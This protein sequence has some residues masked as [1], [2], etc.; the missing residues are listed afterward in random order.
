MG[1]M[2]RVR[3]A[4]APALVVLASGWMAGAAGGAPT[5][6]GVRLADRPAAVRVAVLLA[7]GP[8]TAR[9]GEVQA[10]DPTAEDGRAVVEVAGADPGEVRGAVSGHGVTVRLRAR[11]GRLL[12]VLDVAPG[13][14]KFVSYATRGAPGRLVIDLWKAGAVGRDA[15]IGADGCLALRAWSGGRGR[16][17]ARGLE[18]RPLFERSLVLSLRDGAG[19]RLG[20][21]ALTAR[22]GRLRPDGA[23]YA[24]PG[25][26]AGG[27]PYRV[28]RPTR[29]MLEAWVTSARDGA[30]EC[31]VQ[32]PVRLYPGAG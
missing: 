24:R 20:L 5:A 30:L 16:A 28:A 14:V 23:G 19:R 21:R 17:R 26:F 27:V 4:W 6:T 11:P 12:V 10:L 29:A 8:V 25:W 9:E 31:L 7:G 18:L 15:A 2:G 32:V 3:W 13:R 22:G 1:R